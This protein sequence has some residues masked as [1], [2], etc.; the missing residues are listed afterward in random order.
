LTDQERTLVQTHTVVGQAMLEGVGGL[1]GEVGA[2]VRSCHE[3]YD[4]LG[5]RTSWPARRYRSRPGSSPAATP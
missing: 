3:R 2:I 5:T 4:G 1:L